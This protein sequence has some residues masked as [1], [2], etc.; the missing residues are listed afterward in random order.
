MS[1]TGGTTG[2]PKGVVL[3]HRS[4]VLT[5][6]GMGIEY[7]SYS[8]LVRSASLRSFMA[9]DWLTPWHPCSSEGTAG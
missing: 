3:S 9:P 2:A 7:G 1:Y 8:P 6:M 5:F 4:R